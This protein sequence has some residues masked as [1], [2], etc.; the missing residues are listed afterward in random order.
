MPP[1]I[2]GVRSLSSLGFEAA[3]CDALAKDLAELSPF[4]ERLLVLTGPAGSGTSTTFLSV[5][6]AL[7]DVHVCAIEHRSSVRLPSISQLS[8]EGSG[9]DVRSALRSALRQD[10]DVVA[11]D[12]P[13][14]DEDLALCHK[15]A[16]TGHAVVLTLDERDAP[17]ALARIQ[18]AFGE[19]AIPAGSRVVEHLDGFVRRLVTLD[20]ATADALAAG[21]D[22]ASRI[23]AARR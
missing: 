1:G 11:V 13:L 8:L 10:P 4:F 5:L 19:H 9:S 2:Q 17:A 7:P 18:R 20:E 23:A 14:S 12:A 3:T 15:V 6:A 16:E 21:E 22:V